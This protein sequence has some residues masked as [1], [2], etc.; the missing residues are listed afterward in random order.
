MDKL[1]FVVVF[2]CLTFSPYGAFCQDKSNGIFTYVDMSLESGSDV[3][4]GL[5]YKRTIGNGYDVHGYI[6]YSDQESVSVGVDYLYRLPVAK[7]SL[8]FVVGLGMG[9]EFASKV[10]RAIGNT[11]VGLFRP[12]AG[13]DFCLPNT[14]FG[15]FG[16]YKPKLAV[17]GGMETSTVQFGAGFRF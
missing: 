1:F 13:F 5:Q 3:I 4:T 8:S 12:Q 2:C 6:G 11:D 7:N 16:V 10:G 14:P 9:I 17:E 15:I